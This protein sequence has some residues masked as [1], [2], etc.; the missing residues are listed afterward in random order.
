[1]TEVNIVTSF[2]ENLL[3]NTTHYLLSSLKE[4]LEPDVKLT[5]YY[6]DC[7]LDAY[8]IPDNI[9]YKKLDDIKD[10]KSFLERYAQ[11]DGTEEGKIPYNEKLDVIKWSHKV[12]AL[13]L[14][15]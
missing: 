5:A 11:H 4:N 12:L 13:A 6:H 9:T 7:N 2:N 3:K 1:M 15:T 14:R 8:S 10:Y